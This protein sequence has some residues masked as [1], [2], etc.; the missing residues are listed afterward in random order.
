MLFSN[1][2]DPVLSEVED[3]PVEL[4]RERGR[5]AGGSTAPM[6]R[7][8]NGAA[9]PSNAFWRSPTFF[10]RTSAVDSAPSGRPS[11]PGRSSLT[12]H[13]CAASSSGMEPCSLAAFLGVETKVTAWPRRASRL[14]RSRNVIMWPNASH[15]NT[16][17]WRA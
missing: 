3:D 7:R 12:M 11:T 15:G 8:S 10:G 17:M 2:P 6:A 5:L 14:E 1:W 16:T 4:P 9:R 13:R